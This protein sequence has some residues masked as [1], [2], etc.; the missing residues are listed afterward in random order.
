MRAW[1]RSTMG[2]IWS[3]SG[4]RSCWPKSGGMPC[5]DQGFGFRSY[6]PTIRPLASSR[7]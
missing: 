3:K 5:A 4:A 2:W 6:G 1:A 7:T